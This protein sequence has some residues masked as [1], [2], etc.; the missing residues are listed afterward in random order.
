MNKNKHQLIEYLLD[1]V[2]RGAEYPQILLEN[3]AY[4]VNAEVTRDI[5]REIYRVSKKDKILYS[6]NFRDTLEF[7]TLYIL[8]N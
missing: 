7:L 1:Y 4:K 6:G 8:D 5:H 3:I 2:E